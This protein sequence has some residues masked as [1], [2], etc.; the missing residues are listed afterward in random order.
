[1]LCS[2]GVNPRRS[3]RSRVFER[4]HHESRSSHVRSIA[5]PR[6]LRICQEA[7]GRHSECTRVVSL[8]WQWR[9]KL[10]WQAAGPSRGGEAGGE[11]FQ[12]DHVRRLI[13]DRLRLHV[14]QPGSSLLKVRGAAPS[15]RASRLLRRVRALRRRR[16]R[17]G[18]LPY[19]IA[20]HSPFSTMGPRALSKTDWQHRPPKQSS[21]SE[22]WGTLI[23]SFDS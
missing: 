12:L 6:L 22:S 10:Q 23:A 19:V 1:M 7:V 8:A 14:D 20:S 21:G 5:R 3:D 2:L 15:S 17:C 9:P 13:P 11:L 4:G 16:Q 18:Q